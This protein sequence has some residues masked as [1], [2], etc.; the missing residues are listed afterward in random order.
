MRVVSTIAE[1]REAIRAAKA[2]G[3]L[4]GFVPTMGA[5]HAGHL[6]LMSAARR[7]CGFVV[8]SIFVNPTQFAPSEDLAKYPR[9]LESDAA[10][11]ETEGVDIIFA[12]AASGVYPAGF[13]TFIEVGG[14]TNTLEGASRPG[15]FRGVATVVAKLLNIVQPDKVYFGMKDYQQLLVIRRMVRDLDLPVDIVPVATVREED[16][17][18][19]SSRNAYLNPEERSAAAVLYRALKSAE[20]Q[21]KSGGASPMEVQKSLVD[22][23]ESEPLATVDY[24]AVVDP[25]T[26]ALPERIDTRI[27]VALAVRIGQTRLIDN[28]L[29]EL[30]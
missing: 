6:K 18:A 29:I 9:D 30:K 23:I 17:L 26:L 5:L 8:V 21:V 1:T 24:V 11:S 27:L 28:A 19:M 22:L 2:E 15:H 14:C 7:E 12:P 4:V 16:G 3:K 25:E 20:D 13:D 10:K